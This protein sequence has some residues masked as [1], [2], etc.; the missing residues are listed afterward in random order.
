MSADVKCVDMNGEVQF[1]LQ[2]KKV[3]FSARNLRVPPR[4]LD[5]I[6]LTIPEQPRTARR[7]LKRRQTRREKNYRVAL[8]FRCFSFFPSSFHSQFLLVLVADGST[9]DCRIITIADP[10]SSLSLRD[11]HVMYALSSGCVCAAVDC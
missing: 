7:R 4:I 3:C 8:D 6:R 11:D 2:S 10:H 1:R 9:V 5:E